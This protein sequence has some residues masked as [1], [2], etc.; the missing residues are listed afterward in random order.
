MSVQQLND[1]LF[2][3]SANNL[4]VEG[5]KPL[6]AVMN[7]NGKRK[8]NKL[9]AT[10]SYRNRIDKRGSYFQIKGT[11]S[12]RKASTNGI[13]DYSKEKLSYRETESN[14]SV[15]K[16]TQIEPK[17]V[18]RFANKGTLASGLA[19]TYLDDDNDK[20]LFEKIY[21]SY[22]KQMVTLAVSILN[23]NDDAEDT[24]GDVFLRIAQKNFDVVRGI[25][26]DIDLRNYLL[27]A[28]KNTSINKINT[29][30]KDNVSLDTVVEYNMDKIKELSDDTFIEFVCN[31]I[32]YDKI[33]EAER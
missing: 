14:N 4:F 33:I 3:E 12:Y 17:I 1:S 19:Y 31:R 23:N 9:D 27:K 29:K 2:K 21:N 6:S 11:Y 16:V 20:R 25:K 24:V 8:Y 32:D 26:N 7:G 13:Y 22:K 28:T 18:Y 10:A 30:K 15:T 5:E